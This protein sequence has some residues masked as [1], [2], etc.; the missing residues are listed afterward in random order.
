M[1]QRREGGVSWVPFFFLKTASWE[2]Q[3]IKK[4]SPIDSSQ[5]PVRH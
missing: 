3:D 5:L 1:E 2:L 4:K